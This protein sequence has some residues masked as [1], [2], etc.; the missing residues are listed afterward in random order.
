[1]RGPARRA[2]RLLR[3]FWR[4][5]DPL[6]D[7]FDPA[8][9]RCFPRDYDVIDGY[10]ERFLDTAR[11]FELFVKRCESITTGRGDEPVGVAVMP[12]FETPC[13]WFAVAIGLGLAQRGRSVVF[14]W[15]DMPFP[16]PSADLNLQNDEISKVMRKLKRRFPVLRLSQQ[17]AESRGEVGDDALLDR[18]AEA[19]L[20][21]NLRGAAPSERDIRFGLRLRNTLADALPRVRSLMRDNGFRYAVVPA[22]VIGPSG[23]YLDEGRAAGVRVATFDAGL[24]WSIVNVDGV[25]AQQTDT[26]R[27]FK[28]LADDL[29]G[30]HGDV[31][32]AAREEFER[33][34][35]GLDQSAYQLARPSGLTT[36]AEPSIL[37]PLSVVFDASAL[38]RH[39]IFADS[40][41]WLVETISALLQQTR[42]RIVVRQ[43][44]SE[45]RSTERSR[46][47]VKTILRESFGSN[48]QVRFIAAEEDV[49]TYD[50]LDVS[51]LV[52][53]FVSTIGIE[54]AALGKPVIVCGSVYYADLGF[55]WAPSSREEYFELLGRGA[56]DGLPMLP[57]QVNR[58]WRCYYLNVACNRV[59]TDFTPQPPDFWRWAARQPDELYRDP[60]V[61]DILTSIDENVPLAILRHERRQ[62]SASTRA[63]NA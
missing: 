38:G 40:E 62:Q 54:A 55:V 43:H 48:S 28:L 56:S 19:N 24:G 34:R 12:W 63:S 51:R 47:D 17:S 49:S 45:R 27:A 1:M 23:L 4:R 41:E 39:H 29:Q 21:W 8:R 22:G 16:E 44:P 11:V 57:D 25:A 10:K 37:I 42:D 26:P 13:P 18:L 15:H 52:L 3:R 30:R 14:V 59:W 33:R 50:L 20:T 6:V 53:P 7:F 31:I 46:F 5:A 9:A 32:E 58:A 2:K 60:G 36:S 35:S 61:D